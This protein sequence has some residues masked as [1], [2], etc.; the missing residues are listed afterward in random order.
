M[1][2]LEMM[3]S[4]NR[5]PFAEMMDLKITEVRLGYSRVEIEVK[6][7]HLNPIGTVHGGCL[8]TM[9]DVAAGSAAASHGNVAPTLDSSFHYLNAG[10]HATH[11]IAEAHELKFG[12]RTMV[13]E[14]QIKDQDELLLAVGT[15]TFMSIGAKHSFAEK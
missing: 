7:K 13:Y 3:Q 15:F 6:E 8:Y 1:N 9:A 12:K 4:A 2:Y 5:N 14:V 11:L 10:M